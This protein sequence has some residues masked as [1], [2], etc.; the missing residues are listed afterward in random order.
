MKDQIK[1]LNI[2]KVGM[3]K[4]AHWI[5]HFYRWIGYYVA[6]IL[7]HTPISPNLVTASRL[8]WV[9]IAS[10]CIYFSEEW[11]YRLIAIVCLFLFSMLDA[12]DGTLA[13][14]IDK[15]SVL[16]SWLDPLI[17]RFGLLILS[18]SIAF[19]FGDESVI[20]STSGPID[21]LSP[22]ITLFL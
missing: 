16:G 14:M 17:D 2:D 1:P 4:H 19:M 15:K 12:A 9:L 20:K 3:K 5:K 22:M 8:L 7:A 11:S 6:S 18:L 10:F 21:T 13:V